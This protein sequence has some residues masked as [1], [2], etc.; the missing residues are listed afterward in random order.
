MWNSLVRVLFIESLQHMHFPDFSRNIW[1]WI[2]YLS[3]L[4]Q[5][6][7]Y[8]KCYRYVIYNYVSYQFFPPVLRVVSRNSKILEMWRF[9]HLAGISNESDTKSILRKD[10]SF[11]LWFTM[12]IN[13][14]AQ[15]AGWFLYM[16]FSHIF[17]VSVFAVSVGT[18]VN[19]G[20]K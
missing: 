4:F 18:L 6:L 3:I 7:R 14:Q 2:S 8:L 11:F 10:M 20:M 16:S 17:F 13:G 12:F 19:H 15:T 1:Y 9:S 5:N